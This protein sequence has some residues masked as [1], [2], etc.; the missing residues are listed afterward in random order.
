MSRSSST[1]VEIQCIRNLVTGDTLKLG[2]YRELN[3]Y[4]YI[5]VSCEGLEDILCDQWSKKVTVVGNVNPESVLKRVRR[6]KKD[7]DLWQQSGKKF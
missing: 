3:I 4:T 6:V 1:Y 7:A 5:L 2:Q